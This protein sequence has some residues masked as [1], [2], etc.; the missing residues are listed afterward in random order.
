MVEA[1]LRQAQL[2]LDQTVVRAPIRGVVVERNAVIG[3]SVVASPQVPPLFAVAEDLHAREVHA[4]IDEADIGRVRPGQDAALAFDAYPGRPFRGRV[5][6]V[7]KMPEVVQGVVSYDVVISADNDSGDL[8]PGMTAD[9]RIVAGEAA[10]A[11]KVP[12]AALRFRPAGAKP[13]LASATTGED[14]GTGSVWRLG[15]HG[16]PEEIPVTPGLTDGAFTQIVAGSVAAGDQVIVSASKG[17]G[18]SARVGPLR[19]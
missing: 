15:R 6:D 5:L 14:R 2:D 1:A 19:F 12:N 18:E 16:K 7:H 10:E 3:Q 17:A 9:V 11:L 4:S 8:L 13:H